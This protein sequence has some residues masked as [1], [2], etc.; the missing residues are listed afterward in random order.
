MKK[1]KNLDE[2]FKDNEKF[3]LED[4]SI[5]IG[6]GPC[7]MTISDWLNFLTTLWKSYD[8]A[9]SNFKTWKFTTVVLYIT[10]GTFF[11]AVFSNFSN[12]KSDPF[13]LTILAMI[14]YIGV[15]I[16]IMLTIDFYG[17]IMDH[18]ADCRN[19]IYVIINSIIWG[20]LRDTDIIREV[21]NRIAEE[22]HITAQKI[23]KELKLDRK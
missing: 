2:I 13:L 14:T 21:W 19:K 3:E 6:H 10:I 1:V 8:S 23:I 4:G 17:K 11:I 20:S 7:L 12:I 5:L 15:F 22:N 16:G 18:Q 9:L